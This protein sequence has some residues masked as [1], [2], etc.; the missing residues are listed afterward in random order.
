MER[1]GEITA[2]FSELEW[3]MAESIYM[4]AT[5]FETEFAGVRDERVLV[6]IAGEDF[7]VL[8]LKLRSICHYC[9]SDRK[10]LKTFDTFLD[11]LG[12]LNGKRNEYVHTHNW[13]FSVVSGMWRIKIKRNP[14]KQI[15]LLVET[16]TSLK[17]MDKLIQEASDAIVQLIRLIDHN[18]LSIKSQFY[19]KFKKRE[20]DTYGVPPDP[21]PDTGSL[22]F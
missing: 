12:Q 2:T 11:Y 9:I 17:E 5:T 14:A 6:L 3:Q 7:R 22:P 16:K 1:L 19:E 20:K 18:M 15:D 4:L 10:M 13:D 21:L 8:L